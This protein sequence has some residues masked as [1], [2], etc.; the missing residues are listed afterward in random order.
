MMDLSNRQGRSEQG[1]LIQ[2]AIEKAGLSVEEL[3]NRIG[4]SRALIYQYLSGTTLAQPDRLQQIAAQTGVTL[5]YFYGAELP[6]EARRT[7]RAGERDDPHVRLAER[8]Q[9]L[10]EL[11]HAQE[12][13]PDWSA[14]ASTCERI[15][16][17]AS[18]MDDAKVEARALLR[19]GKARIRNGEF[20]RSVV[21]L[22]RAAALFAAMN[23]ERG[24]ADARQALGHALLMTGR[25]AEA[26]EQFTWVANSGPWEARWSGKVS[27]AAVDEQLGDYRQA[28]QRCD[29]AAVILEE[30]SDLT[31]VAHGM[32]YVNANRV[33][34]YMACGDFKSAQTLAE[35]CLEE[36]ESLGNSDQHLEARLNL[37]VCAIWQGRW[38]TARRL[39]FATFQMARFLGDRSREAMSRAALALLLAALG[40]ADPAIEHAKD[41]LAAALSQGDHRA[42]LFAQMALS[43]AYM[44]SGRMSEARYHA[45]QALGVATALRLSLYIAECRLRIVRLCLRAND[46]DDAREYLER[47]LARA[48]QLGARHLE[49]M[50]CLL[51]GELRLHSGAPE[52]A[53]E[54]A[55]QARDLSREL[56]IA[57]LGWEADALL[58]RAAAASV[59]PRLEEAIEAA[60]RATGM[61]EGIRS[62][63][64]E[65]GIPDTLLED[66]ER[67]EAYLLYARLMTDAGRA[68]DAAAFIEQAGWP[69]L[70][71]R[72]QGGKQVEP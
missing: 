21:G 57:P 17:L 19:L 39:L 24:E 46:L 64:R 66:E 70:S 55:R 27:L 47:A 5:A 53:E 2:K 1:Q 12:S 69:P 29:E 44:C 43:D 42:E 51:N 60:T 58:A 56:G 50:S 35:R 68:T 33:N 18:Q 49:A 32:L 40:D 41:A 4:C 31:D 23:E 62:D 59:P 65:A 7:R 54:G 61:M 52:A 13:N 71:V 6:E 36:S 3:A 22:S 34:L 10:E 11:A 45:N 20:S 72:F 14:L 67:Q 30:G 16:S 8:I 9:Q 37:G 26:R 48:Q 15:I 25:I 63:L 38:T 28:M